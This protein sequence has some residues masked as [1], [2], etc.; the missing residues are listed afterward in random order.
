M[1]IP[2]AYSLGGG[3]CSAGLTGYTY[4]LQCR[5]NPLQGEFPDAPD[6]RL[7]HSECPY[8][9]LLVLCSDFDLFEIP[10]DEEWVK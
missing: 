4:T 10:D 7:T 2:M 5:Y 8:T 3:G 1:L 9:V 6:F